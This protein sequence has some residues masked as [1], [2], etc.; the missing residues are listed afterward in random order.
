MRKLYLIL[1][2]LVLVLPARAAY[3]LVPMDDTQTNHLKAYGITYWVLENQITAQW[4]L[5]YRGGS[6]LI[7]Y[8]KS[9]ETECVI[10]N[11]S[12]EVLAD[13]SCPDTG[14]MPMMDD[15]SFSDFRTVD[16]TRI[17]GGNVPGYETVHLAKTII[18]HGTIFPL[19]IEF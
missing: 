7:P 8:S 11:V 4:L 3:L 18:D 1:I 17:L 16:G 14:A 15:E 19:A 6:F 12:F 9:V 10:R 2:L 13:A 5:N